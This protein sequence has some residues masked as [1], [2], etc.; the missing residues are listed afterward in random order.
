MKT[1]M[2]EVTPQLQGTFYGVA[3]VA[4]FWLLGLFFTV[5]AK[6]HRSV[7]ES[8][9][10]LQ[11]QHLHKVHVGGRDLWEPMQQ[12]GLLDTRIRTVDRLDLYIRLVGGGSIVSGVVGFIVL[13][14]KESYGFTVTIGTLAALLLELLPFI[15]LAAV[16]ATLFVTY[17]AIYL[18][19]WFSKTADVALT[20]HSPNE[21]APPKHSF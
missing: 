7:R 1:R 9:R 15:S 18:D 17:H 19:R 6:L 11:E 10:N 4:G 21:E 2:S 5:C 8:E 14:F 16:L 3:I 20:S 12:K 13:G